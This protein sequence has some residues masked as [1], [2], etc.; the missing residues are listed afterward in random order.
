MRGKTVCAKRCKRL[1]ANSIR[2]DA[3]SITTAIAVA[4]A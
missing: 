3:T 4:S 2:N 1:I